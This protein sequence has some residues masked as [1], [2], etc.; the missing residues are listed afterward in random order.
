MKILITGGAGYI[1]STIALCLADHG[2]NVVVLDD[3]S[4]GVAEFV[5][6]PHFYHGDIGDT[7]LVARLLDEHPDITAV[8][9]CAG[10]IVVPESV[11]HPY[12]YFDTNFVHTLRLLRTLADHGVHRFVL[13]STASMYAPNASLF[14]DESTPVE[15]GNPYATSKHLL[16]QALRSLA[17]VTDLRVVVLRYANPIGADPQLRTGLQN[18]TPTHALGGLLDAID[19]DEPFS[20]T[21]TDWHTRDGTG[22]RDYVHVWDIA[23]AH[24]VALEKFDS[25]VSDDPAHRFEI[26][27]LGSGTGTTV[28]ELVQACADTLG[29][30]PEIAEVQRRPGDVAGCAIGSE[31]AR[32]L[33][34]WE[35]ELSIEAAIG[36]AVAWREK[37]VSARLPG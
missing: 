1:G 15:P 29:V 37:W 2:V 35:P 36:D 11:S 19:R 5:R 22:V 30:T 31:R 26:I 33:L 14:A 16:E 9:H 6:T 7:A 8:I 24:R 23:R 20:I 34:G 13:S 21:G 4:T 10:R 3:L 32:R 28:R 18:F 17:S 12:A 25:L 27:N